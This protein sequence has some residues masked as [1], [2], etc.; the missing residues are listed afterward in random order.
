M[1]LLLYLY[2]SL[3]IPALMGI[4]WQVRG[5]ERCICSGW[6]VFH[7]RYIRIL[8]PLSLSYNNDLSSI[9]LPIQ[10][11]KSHGGKGPW[12]WVAGDISSAPPF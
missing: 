10:F 8:I 12:R 4:V 7:L 6:G 1:L 2:R 5:E 11:I 3:L 9:T